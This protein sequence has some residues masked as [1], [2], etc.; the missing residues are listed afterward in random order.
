MELNETFRPCTKLFATLLREGA[1]TV[2]QMEY[3]G[4]VQTG[5]RIGSR[6]VGPE[7][8]VSKDGTLILLLFEGASLCE[9]ALL[10]HDPQAQPITDSPPLLEFMGRYGHSLTDIAQATRVSFTK[11]TLP[12]NQW[13]GNIAQVIA[14]NSNGVEIDPGGIVPLELGT[15]YFDHLL[16]VQP[17]VN[18]VG[19][20]SWWFSFT[21]NEAKR[22][23]PDYRGVWG[24]RLL[25][26][27]GTNPHGP[28]VCTDLQPSPEI[29]PSFELPPGDY[30]L[31][32]ALTHEEA[33]PVDPL[34]RNEDFLFRL[35]DYA[36]DYAAGR[37][38]AYDAW[39]DNAYWTAYSRGEYDART[40]AGF[41]I[42]RYGN[43]TLTDAQFANGGSRCEGYE[44]GYK[45]GW[46]DAHNT[47]ELAG[48]ET[49]YNHWL[50]QQG[51]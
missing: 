4:R 33:N 28:I 1:R 17:S 40:G 32:L 45:Q 13:T 24:V 3:G 20:K 18:R 25:C 50:S 47:A 21:L 6:A 26:I 9:Y 37:Q 23:D 12:W 43:K 46:V 39:Y 31:E 22:L 48:Y 10:A 44:N 11:E 8:F 41:N 7:A 51:G 42:D 16:Q 19:C 2:Y 30:I 35:S 29:W 36:A 27:S 14:G 49:G 34:N 5:K 15:D 38:A